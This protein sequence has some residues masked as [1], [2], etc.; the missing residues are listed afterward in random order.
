MRLPGRFRAGIRLGSG[1]WVNVLFVCGGNACLSIMAESI[2]RSLGAGRFGAFSAGCLPQDAVDDPVLDFLASHHMP[3]RGLH[4]KRLEAFRGASAPKVEFIITL[5]DAAAG[6][7]FSE[8]PG[9]PFVAHWNVEEGGAESEGA[10]PA[11]AIRDNF[12]VL[13][14]RI[15]IFASLPHGKLTRRLLE[16]RV[17]ALE[18]G[19][20]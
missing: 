20:H 16:Q 9:E 18:T 19:Y 17:R 3:I 10:T 1:V 8:W 14:R 6:E 15:K 4:P 5:C 12:W 13:M 11:Q 7:D 2:L